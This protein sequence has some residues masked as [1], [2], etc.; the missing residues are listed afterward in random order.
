MSKIKNDLFVDS[1]DT[2]NVN[3]NNKKDSDSNEGT[4]DLKSSKE[5]MT[6]KDDVKSFKNSTRKKEPVKGDL[7][8][9]KDRTDENKD[10]DIEEKDG[11]I[12][13]NLN[14]TTDNDTGKKKLTWKEKREERRIAKENY[15]KHVKEEKEHWRSLSREE[16]KEERKLR[17]AKLFDDTVKEQGRQIYKPF[18]WGRLTLNILFFPFR[19]VEFFIKFL[20]GSLNI[21]FLIFAICCFIG[22]FAFTKIYPTYQEATTKAYDKL[23]HLRDSNF[24]MFENTRIYDKDGNKLGEIN[25]GD[26]H[27]V[28]IYSKLNGNRLTSRKFYI[29]KDEDKREEKYYIWS[30]PVAEES[31]PAIPKYKLVLENKDE[32]QAFIN[33]L[34]EQQKEKK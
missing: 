9:V 33:F 12:N 22:V 26:Y 19:V 31:Q 25:A 13:G 4:K 23:A 14:E 10:N 8:S 6:L 29:G 16:K 18:S 1:E 15:K 21:V 27:Y 30:M 7:K 20:W 11:E 17:Y 32:V 2:N 28:D 34:Q 3:Q 24:R 5:I